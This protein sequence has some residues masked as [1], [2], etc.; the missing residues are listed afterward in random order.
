MMTTEGTVKLI[1]F[2]I[3]ARSG[4][5][6]SYIAGKPAYMAPE[7][8]VERRADHRSDIFALGTVLYEMLT[9]ERLFPGDTA[10]E[11]LERVVVGRNPSF[12]PTPIPRSRGRWRPSCPT[13]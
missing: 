10:G 9:G 11:V 13:P 7:M 2:G 8:V 3:A 1:D 4:A 12:R 5:R 6:E